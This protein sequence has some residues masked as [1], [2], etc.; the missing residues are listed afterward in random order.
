[1]KIQLSETHFM[2]QPHSDFIARDY[3]EMWREGNFLHIDGGGGSSN[4]NNTTTRRRRQQTSSQSSTVL[5]YNSEIYFKEFS[6]IYI[7]LYLNVV[8]ISYPIHTRC[9]Q[10][11]PFSFELLFFCQISPT[12]NE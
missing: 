6:L 11:Y 1:M 2:V 10:P 4:D 5:V 8:C 9:M 7:F 12:Q 3:L